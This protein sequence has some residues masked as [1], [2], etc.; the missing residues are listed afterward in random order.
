[1]TDRP[2]KKG[3]CLARIHGGPPRQRRA[4]AHGQGGRQHFQRPVGVVNRKGTGD[5]QGS[6]AGIAPEVAA[7]VL[8]QGPHQFAQCGVFGQHAIAVPKPP[9]AAAWRRR[10]AAL[11][12]RLRRPPERSGPVPA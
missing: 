10:Q 3:T 8:A 11:P 5:P 9:P 7:A 2:Q 12:R 1:M 4:H 6:H